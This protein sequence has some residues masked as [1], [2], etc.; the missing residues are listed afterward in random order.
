MAQAAICPL[1]PTS[2]FLSLC[3]NLKEN[4]A[5]SSCSDAGSQAAPYA[6]L[7]L[8]FCLQRRN[9]LIAPIS[10][11]QQQPP[12]ATGQGSSGDSEGTT[13]WQHPQNPW[14]DVPCKDLV[15]WVHG[16]ISGHGSRGWELQ[17][18]PCVTQSRDSTHTPPG[19][20]QSLLDAVSLGFLLY[21]LHLPFYLKILFEN[22][23]RRLCHWQQLLV[24][25][26]SPYFL[27]N[28]HLKSSLY[29]SKHHFL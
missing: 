27:F 13:P 29:Y 26:F 12:Q 4:G 8:L 16:H 24:N 5:S 9:P 7:I 28:V 14:G 3:S 6:L 15:L 19:M 10:P 18:H 20:L 21:F 11:I 1:C 22:H 17:L 2:Q 25:V 23:T